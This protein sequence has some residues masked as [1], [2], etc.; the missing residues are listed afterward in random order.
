[1]CPNGM[2]RVEKR[3]VF[4]CAE[5]DDFEMTKKFSGIAGTP[6]DEEYNRI[7]PPECCPVCGGEIEGSAPTSEEQDGGD[8]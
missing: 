4:T 3:E 6:G 8:A 1:M 2:D 7:E 5:C